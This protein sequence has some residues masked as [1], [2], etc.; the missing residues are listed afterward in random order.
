MFQVGEASIMTCSFG[1]APSPLNVDPSN[2]IAEGIPIATILDFAPFANI[3]SFAICQ[4]PANPACQPAMDTIG[5]PI[6]PC[7]PATIMPW[8]PGALNVL[9]GGMPALDDASITICAYAGVIDIIIPSI[10]TVLVE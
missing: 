4:S 10:F 3:I 7:I 5:Y 1:M 8:V 6:G 2:I 9:M